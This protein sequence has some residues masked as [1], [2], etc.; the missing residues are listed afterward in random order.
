MQ[1]NTDSKQAPTRRGLK[2]NA[3]EASHDAQQALPFTQDCRELHRIAK[4]NNKEAMHQHAQQQTASKLQP[5]GVLKQNA[6]EASHDA[7]QALPFTQEYPELHK[8]AGITIGTQY[9]SKHSTRQQASSNKEGIKKNASEASHDAHQGLPFTQDCNEL[10]RI[11]KETVGKQCISVRSNR[12]QAS[13]NQEGIQTKPRAKRAM[14][15]CRPCHSY[16]STR[17]YTG[18]R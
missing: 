6:S 11:A 10:H 9:I 15:H 7:Q 14:M 1:S 2:N 13:S 18:L 8:I 4:E 5:G 12:Q 3:S 17:N 16:P